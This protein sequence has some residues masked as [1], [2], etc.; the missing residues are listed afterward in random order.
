MKLL[1]FSVL[2][3]NDQISIDDCDVIERLKIR[4]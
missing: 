3:R 2:K 1:N 4:H